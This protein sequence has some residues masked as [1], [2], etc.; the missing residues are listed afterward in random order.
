MKKF[1]NIYAKELQFSLPLLY[2]MQFSTKPSYKAFGYF[3]MVL[4]NTL[5]SVLNMPSH[6]RL[7][8]VFGLNFYKKISI[9]SL[10]F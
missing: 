8:Y 1:G 4:F 7:N 2:Y 5:E 3:V 9:W 10:Y 6:F